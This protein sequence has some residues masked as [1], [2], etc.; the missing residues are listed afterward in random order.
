MKDNSLAAR[1]TYQRKLKGYSQQELAQ[2][3]SVTVRT[4]QRIESGTVTPHLQTIK[5]LAAALEIEVDQLMD[6]EDPKKESIQQKW[7]LLM[8]G[9][10]LV[11]MAI[12]FLN[13]L[14]PLFLWIHKREDNEIYDV[15]GRALSTFTLRSPFY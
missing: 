6:L 14:I 7:L 8:H 2:R 15:H 11:G 9:A 10:P 4:I 3:T 5:L 1:L 13:V 12:P